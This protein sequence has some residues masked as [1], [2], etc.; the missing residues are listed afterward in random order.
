[1]SQNEKEI[2]ENI[3]FDNYK[4][5]NEK[6]LNHVKNSKE[7]ENIIKIIDANMEY[8]ENGLL[9]NN[10]TNELLYK[11]L[12]IILSYSKSTETGIQITGVAFTIISA[13]FSFLAI[14]ISIFLDEKIPNIRLVLFSI[15]ILI[16]LFIYICR[17]L[18]FK[19]DEKN[20]FSYNYLIKGMEFK[21]NNYSMVEY[22]EGDF[23][24]VR[25]KEIKTN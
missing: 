10:L 17:L 8:L 4:F 15:I 23:F 20:S 3:F 1:M 19:R 25:V 12:S 11:S 24:L 2:D 9:S 22:K 16:F 21:L 18:R 7:I 14:I 5:N 6:F 13:F